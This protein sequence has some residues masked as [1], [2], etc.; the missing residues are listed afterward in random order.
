MKLA[1]NYS[2]NQVFN[3]L[4]K[5]PQRIWIVSILWILMISFFAL[6]WNLGNISLIDE[7]EPLFAEASRQ[8]IER[9]DWITPYFNGV[10]RFDKPILIYWFMAIGFKLI[11]VNEWAVRL[12]SA[13][14]A[15][16]LMIFTFYTVLKFGYLLPITSLNKGENE[17]NMIPPTS[18]I[19]GGNNEFKL[20]IAAILSSS[21]IALNLPII[22]WGKSGVSDMLLTACMNGA[23]LAFF[24]GYATEKTNIKNRWYM[25][26]YVLIS[27]GVLTK[28]PVGIVLPG[29]SILGFLFYVGKFRE[30]FKEVKVLLGMI[31]MTIIIMPWYILVTLKNGD[32]FI[33]SFFGYHNLERFTE[34]VN[35]HSAV[36][37]FYFLV[38]IIGF[39]PWSMYLPLAM[40]KLN[41]LQRLKWQN[42]SR[43]SQ[44]GLFMLFWFLVVFIFFNVAVTKLPS[45]MLPLMPASAILVGLL[46]GN[47]IG[48]EVEN[49][50]G[51]GLMI[52]VIVNLIFVTIF[53][54]FCVY[55]TKIIGYDPAVPNLR[56]L[57]TK[58]GL[59][60]IGGIVWGLMGLGL[61]I[62]L[63][64][65]Q[66]KWVWSVNLIGFLAFIIFWVTPAYFLV[67]EVRQL[68]LRELAL[69]VKQIHK[70]LQEELVMIG[71]KKPSIVFYAQH[72]FNFF[73]STPHDIAE[74]MKFMQSKSA[75]KAI[76]IITRDEE[77]KQTGLQKNQYE[78]LEQ[79]G[80][81]MLIKINQNGLGKN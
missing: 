34:V 77:L 80:V 73:N 54:I 15:I 64:K 65:K 11:G 36:W 19:K 10:T 23:L 22:L 32:N 30:V 46:F 31:I 52:S 29:M 62:L 71:F 18:L 79:K 63:V 55:M 72:N 17:E 38:V 21:L 57:V 35:G 9:N 16:A 45:Y 69:T 37:Y 5:S 7:T 67:D 51:K 6:L 8:L 20:W 44:L 70:P 61:V 41:I 1:K 2:L 56:E 59:P 4:N 43:E 27:L 68:P 40:S 13:L 39:M 66:I 50:P 28:G 12:P 42:S 53:T 60:I 26:F 81:Y 74:A 24:Q 14:S 58:S 33:N 78:K 75:K 3:N 48:E 25:G 76:L 49:K 47:Y